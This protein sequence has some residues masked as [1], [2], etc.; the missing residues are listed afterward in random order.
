MLLEV[1]QYMSESTF[2]QTLQDSFYNRYV[3]DGKASGKKKKSKIP[4]ESEK[5]TNLC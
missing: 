3:C 2:E 4:S 5:I 1:A